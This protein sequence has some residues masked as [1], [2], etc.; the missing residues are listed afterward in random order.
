[1]L[2][3][4]V[5]LE[6]VG[7]NGPNSKSLNGFKS[8]LE[9]GSASQ[10]DAAAAAAGA[11]AVVKDLESTWLLCCSKDEEACPG[12]SSRLLSICCLVEKYSEKR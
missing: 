7:V 1:L 2:L 11:E 6:A 3:V 4:L 9:A 8:G 10:V 12:R 5:L